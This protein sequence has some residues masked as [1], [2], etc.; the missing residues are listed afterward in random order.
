M[1]SPELRDSQGDNGL[2]AVYDALEKT[3][4]K[5]VPLAAVA[6]LTRWSRLLARPCPIAPGD[7]RLMRKSGILASI[8]RSATFKAEVCNQQ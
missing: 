2:A 5:E 7:S 4:A 1:R 3:Y 6:L 8:H